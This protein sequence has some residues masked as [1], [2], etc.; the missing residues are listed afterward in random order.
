VQSGRFGACLMTEPVLVGEC[1]AAMRAAVDVP[2]TVKCRI[3]VDE[4]D[5]RE[6]FPRF[7]DTVAAAGCEVFVVHARKAWLEGL[8]P[9]ENRDIPPLDHG[10]VREVKRARPDLAITANGGI[11]TL[12]E[13]EAHLAH[14]DG[15]MIGRAAYQTP[16]I[17]ADADARVFGDAPSDRSRWDV[18]AAM[19]DYAARR[20]AEGVPLKSIT[21][22]MMGLFQGL[23]GARAW[24]RMLSEEARDAEAGPDLIRRAA[25]LV[26]RETTREAA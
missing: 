22:H 12:D 25:A 3:G 8:S 19:A 13:T 18:A 7:V 17:L 6:A 24:R 4:Q 1:V 5:P 21:R 20:M 14:V 15:V 11:T 2:V 9:K 26:S 10:L 16:W 23:P